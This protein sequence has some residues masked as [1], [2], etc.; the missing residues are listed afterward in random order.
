MCQA[1][2]SKASK[3]LD[4]AKTGN[5]VELY[6]NEKPD[7]FPDFMEKGDHKHSYPSHKALGILYRTVRQIMAVNDT[8]LNKARSFSPL[9][10]PGWQIFAPGALKALRSY[11][12]RLSHLMEQHGIQSEGE[13][14]SGF[15]GTMSSFEAAN[16]ATVIDL[17]NVDNHNNCFNYHYKILLFVVPYRKGEPG[18]A[19]G[20]TEDCPYG[21]Y[22][23]T[24]LP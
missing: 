10:V 14:F 19:C 7:K 4:F 9:E 23:A 2:V 20:P 12:A 13:I 24:V 15:I 3:A 1:L 18:H 8:K 6:P 17:P 22:E 5:A 16:A 21:G 11:N